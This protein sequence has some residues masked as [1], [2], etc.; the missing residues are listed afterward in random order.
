MYRA[1]ICCLKLLYCLL[2]GQEQ[3]FVVSDLKVVG[4]RRCLSLWWT[5][6]ILPPTSCRFSK[7]RV[8]LLIIEPQVEVQDGAKANACQLLS[9]HVKACTSSQHTS[10]ADRTLMCHLHCRYLC[11]SSFAALS[12]GEISR[13]FMYKGPSNVTLLPSHLTVIPLPCKFSNVSLLCRMDVRSCTQ[14]NVLHY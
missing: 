13:V 11:E 9:L 6:M 12:G 4:E 2:H 10:P 14:Y 5:Q 1:N 8:V 7:T 3:L